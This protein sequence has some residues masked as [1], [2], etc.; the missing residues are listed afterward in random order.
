MR[1]VN[2]EI[3][4]AVAGRIMRPDDLQDAEDW[5]RTVLAEV[6]D[7]VNFLSFSIYHPDETV[8]LEAADPEQWHHSLLSAPHGVEETIQQMG[9]LI[10][11]MAPGREIGLVLDGFNVRSPAWHCAGGVI[12]RRD[13]ECLSAAV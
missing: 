10:R 5:N 11:E 1:A 8:R 3:Q 7:Q 12:C 6:G 2:P 4:L 13:A 9:E